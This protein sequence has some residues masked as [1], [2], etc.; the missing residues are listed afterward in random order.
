MPVFQDHTSLISAIQD[1]LTLSS[2]DVG[3]NMQQLIKE[4]IQEIVY[5]PY[6]PSDLNRQV[7][8][9]RRHENGGFIGSWTYDVSYSGDGNPIIKLYSDAD[10]M[11]LVQ[12]EHVH[13]QPGEGGQTLGLFG[14][15]IDR[16][17]N[18]DIYIQEG[19]GYDFFM[20]S[21]NPDAP[22]S[23]SDNWWAKP[24]NY[25]IPTVDELTDGKKLDTYFRQAFMKN[26]VKIR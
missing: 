5:D 23:E 26:N 16:R 20:V 8:Y 21:N 6:P 12:E 9:V 10:L 4:I 25:F 17:E 22:I 1:D 7:T 14:D 13:G 18:M 11:E 2:F 3:G 19:T 15:E 24:R